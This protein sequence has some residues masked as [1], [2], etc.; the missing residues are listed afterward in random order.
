MTIHEIERAAQLIVQ[1]EKDLYPGCESAMNISGGSSKQSSKFSRSGT[2]STDASRGLPGDL[3]SLI[4][5]N[6][7]TTEPNSALRGE[8]SSLFSDLMTKSMSPDINSPGRSHLNETLGMTPDSFT[9]GGALSTLINRNPYNSTFEA[10]TLDSFQQR[11]SDV[12][13]Q[14]QTGP[15]A[16]RG[17]EAR[18]SIAQGIAS[19]RMAQERGHELRSA[20]NAE[21]GNVLQGAQTWHGI[22]GSRRGQQL[23]GQSQLADG[24]TGLRQQGIGAAQAYE[25][26]KTGNS[27]ML[28]LAMEALGTKG[29]TVTDSL[30]GKGDQSG[31]NL[32]YNML[33]GCCFIFLTALNGKLP[34][35]IDM[36][37][38]QYYT[39]IIKRGYKWMA[40]WLVPRMQRHSL[41]MHLTNTVMIKPFLSY[42]K[43]LYERKGSGW[44]YSP[45]CKAWLTLW[46]TI[47]KVI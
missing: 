39:P 45:Y 44:A 22:E 33:G 21:V 16:V 14:L 42:G 20:Q 6:L 37:R 25:G 10:D 13:S 31:M 27:Q 26:A 34:W 3:T 2:S 9:G 43:W 12:L 8:Q 5:S 17:G 47:G 35:Y 28:N 7:A 4:E 11:G 1:A 23:Q 32:G 29:Q 38:R 41:V 24:I 19:T 30:A 15:D 36:A 40:R 46:K 18:S